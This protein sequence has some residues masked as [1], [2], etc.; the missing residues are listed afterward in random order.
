MQ[1]KEVSLVLLLWYTQYDYRF[2]S[3]FFFRHPLLDEYEYYWRVEP[4]VQYFCDVD[5]DVFQMM[6][7]NKFKYGKV[8][9]ILLFF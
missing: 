4:D 3:G 7:D 5:Y 2:Q 8:S 9:M 6:K 1:V